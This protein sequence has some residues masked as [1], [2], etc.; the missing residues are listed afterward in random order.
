MRKG[1]LLIVA[2]L[3]PLNSMAIDDFTTTINKVIDGDTAIVTFKGKPT[4]FNIRDI[5][6]P[7]LRQAFGPEA[8][9]CLERHL[10]GK[11]VAVQKVYI[12]RDKIVYAN[13]SSSGRD[14]AMSMVW[15][16]CAWPDKTSTTRFNNGAIYNSKDSAKKRKA[17]MWAKPGAIYPAEF[18]KAQRLRDK[19]QQQA[20]TIRARKQQIAARQS[21]QRVG[22][23]ESIVFTDN[24]AFAQKYGDNSQ[25]V[26]N[27]LQETLARLAQQAT[28]LDKQTRKMLI[29]SQFAPDG[30]HLELE[31]IVKLQVYDLDSYQH[32]ITSHEDKFSHVVVYMRYRAKNRL[33]NMGIADIVAG[34]DLQ[35]NML[36]QDDD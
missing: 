3:L 26:K 8:K 22:D 10:V 20:Q 1:L 31:R 13:M 19:K 7:E 6:A 11:P 25:I 14:V 33:G 35:G 34:F 30:R 32:V 28:V 23:S 9:E 27:D 18:R 12:T 24:E 17:G 15:E 5:D 36:W 4:R 2:M 29:S 21:A 16:G